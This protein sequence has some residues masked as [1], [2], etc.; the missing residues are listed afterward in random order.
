V[1][2]VVLPCR[3]LLPLMLM[4]YVPLLLV[5]VVVEA[6]HDRLLLLLLLL[7][8]LLLRRLP[9]GMLWRTHLGAMPKMLLLLLLV[10]GRRPVV[11]WEP[12][13]LALRPWLPVAHMLLLWRRQHVSPTESM[14]RPRGFG[15]GTLLVVRRHLGANGH[16]GHRRSG[17]SHALGWL[18]WPSWRLAVGRCWRRRTLLLWLPLGRRPRPLL[19]LLWLL[20]LL[21]PA[22]TLVS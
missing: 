3:R 14:P 22:R 9:G 1:V 15:K 8:R 17:K 13:V 12:D 19:W 2:V 4:L 20:L 10:H 11:I 5:V 16:C 7:L 6:H 18:P 21:L